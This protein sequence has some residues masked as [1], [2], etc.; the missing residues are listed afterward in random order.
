[1]NLLAVETSAIL[2]SRAEENRKQSLSMFNQFPEKRWYLYDDLGGNIVLKHPYW[3]NIEVKCPHCE[4]VLILE[5]YRAQCCE[6]TFKT[7]FGAIRQVEP[8]GGI[9]KTAEGVGPV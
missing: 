9:I 6:K 5:N 7:G 4:K 3:H 8:V 1:V 2:K